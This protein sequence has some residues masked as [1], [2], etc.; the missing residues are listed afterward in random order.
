MGSGGC[1]PAT[2]AF[3]DIFSSRAVALFYQTWLKYRLHL[4]YESDRKNRFLPMVLSLG[5]LGLAGTQGR[6]EGQGDK[7]GIA[8][9]SLAYYVGALRERPQSAQW[10]SRVVADYFKV[11]CRLEQ[12]VGQ[13]LQLP[14]HEFTKLGTANCALGKS[15]LCGAR[16][17]DRNTKVC[18]TVGPL[19]KPQFDDFLPGKKAANNLKRLF[20][21][22]VGTTFDCEV[23]LILDRQDVAPAKLGSA[24]S[25]LG[26]DG[27]LVASQPASDSRDI[28]YLISAASLT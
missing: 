20:Q 13:W 15:A 4:Q 14:D 24:T 10:F 22:M 7:N 17:W 26:W 23:R 19:R 11:K 12:F 25:R 3:L 27:W 6:L 5:G 16:I 1:I 8:D 9:E 21:M 18:L 2:R 28:A